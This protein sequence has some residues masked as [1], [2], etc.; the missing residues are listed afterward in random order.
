M[1]MLERVLLLL[2]G[3][4]VIVILYQIVKLA[5]LEFLVRNLRK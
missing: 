2:N 3:V 5:W 1:K 4:L